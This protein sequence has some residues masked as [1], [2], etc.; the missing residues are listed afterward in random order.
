MSWFPIGP[1]FVFAPRNANF[2]RL[3]RRNELGR[4]GLVS[5]I[6]IDPNDPATVYVVVRPSSGG[7]SAFRMR[8]EGGIEGASWMPIADSLQQSDPT[9]DPSCIAVNPD[10][11]H[12]NIIY[13]GTMSNN[14]VYVSTTRGNT[15]GVRNAI[16][17]GVRKIIVDPNTASTPATTVLYA[18]TKNGVYRSPDGGVNW[19]QVLAG[20]V[21]SLVANIPP[22]GTPHFYAGVGQTGVFHTTSPT[23]PANW[24]NL[25]AQ[26][27]GLPA[28]DPATQNFDAILV[29]FCPANPDRVYV[30]LAKPN[31]T[32]DLYTTSSPL[33]AWTSVAMTSPPSPAYGYYCFEFAVAPNSP[34]NGTND[35]LFFGSVGLFRSTDGG[36][37]WSGDAIGFHAD[38]QAFAFYPANPPSG[39]IP[40][41]YVGCDGGIAI[42]SKFCDPAFSIS[43]AATDFNEG[44]NY[45]DSGVH[46]NYNHGKQSSAIYQYASDPAIAALGYIGCQDTGVAGGSGTFGWRGMGDAD[47]G[48]IAVARGANGVKVWG[49]WGAYGDWPGF[50]ITLWTDTG[51]YSPAIGWVTLGAGGSLLGGTSNY[52]T[53]L[54]DKCLAGAAVRNSTTL[55]AAIT[56]TGIQAV[57]PASMANIVVGSVLAIDSGGSR[58]TVTVTAVTATTFTANF[59]KT[60][61]AGAF[62]RIELDHNMVTRIDGSGIATQISQD[63]GSSW[64]NRVFIIAAHP[65][66][67]DILYCATKDQKLW[68]TNSGS[69]ASSS[70]LWTEITG[71]KPSSPSMSSIAIDSAGN[72]YVLL[73]HSITTGDPEFGVTSPLFKISGGNWVHQACTGLPTPDVLGF[74]KLVAD[75]VQPNVL[76]ASHDARVYKL[77]LSGGN[78]TWQDISDGLPG[79][80]IYDLWI[81]NIGSSGSPKVLLRSAVPTRG[82]WECDVTAGASDPAISLY[83]RDNFLDQGWLAP[84]PEGIPD[85]YDPTRKVWHYQCADIKIDAQQ[86]GSGTVPAFFQTDPEGSPLPITHVLFNQLNDNSQNL[87]QMDSALVHVQVHNRSRTPANNVRVWAIYCRASG[88]VPALSASPSMGNAFPFWSQFT[89][90]GQIVPNLPADSPWKSVGAPQTLSDIKVTSPKVATWSWTIPTL[91]SGDPGH[92]CMM[93]FIHSASS[94]IS[95]TS[96]NADQVAR[97]NKQIGQKNLHIGPPLP[98]SPSPSGGGGGAGGQPRSMMEEYVEFHNP[99]SETRVASLVFDLQSLPQQLAV[100][101]KLTRLDTVEPLHNSLGGVARIRRPGFVKRFLGC[102]GSLIRWLGWLV[103]WLG[104]W[105]E[106]LGRR[107]LGLPLK[108][109]KF[110]P[111]VKLPDF[112]DTV[113][114]AQPSALVEV[115]GVRL[116]PFGFGAALLSIRNTGTLEEGSEYRFDVQ[117]VVKR[118]VVGGS[119]YVVRVAGEKKIPPPMVPDVFRADLDEDTR[120]RIEREAE[121]LK[122]VPPWAKDI[123]EDRERELGKKS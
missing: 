97:A 16:P 26:G 32:V 7:S 93:V 25:N 22:T 20:N 57:T 54:D 66:D 110:K 44:L 35:I 82:V 15:W 49:I 36:Q 18:A 83:V 64:S 34:G 108:T 61:V 68:M 10:P 52:I 112:E 27:I 100:S 38:Q 6:T 116:P 103:Q 33:T 78:W 74:G 75:P 91:P 28:Y 43:T 77:T 50:R 63:F 104:C 9:V 86:P 87:P 3:S 29:D 55:S 105:I 120:I 121:E 117:Q 99:T 53:G 95:E 123:V 8:T 23:A 62:V 19:T 70:T 109:C 119:T 113:Y 118:T 111:D 51:D 98:S 107:I 12:S 47:A 72:V 106:N 45:T 48:A 60:H 2:K 21:W 114:E 56:A 84:S 76:Y 89:A 65:T 122:Y 115:K 24:T 58:E 13:M 101:F 80:W 79:Q 92:Y 71:T 42:N 14:G 31:T 37:T 4:Q 46:Q 81:G 73:R 102:L 40:D 39:V 41:F 88:G 69:T 1:D 96:M 94:L 17:G 5:H 90:A 11:A 85:P 59:T 30:W 67:A